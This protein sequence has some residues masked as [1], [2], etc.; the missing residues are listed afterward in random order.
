MMHTKAVATIMGIIAAFIVVSLLMA[1]ML[2]DAKLKSTLSES[3]LK[4]LNGEKVTA[5]DIW[6]M[7]VHCVVESGPEATIATAVSSG[8]DM[9]IG[10]DDDISVECIDTHV[11]YKVGKWAGVH[12]KE[13]LKGIYVGVVGDDESKTLESAE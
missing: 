6:G 7:P 13:L 4:A 8:P 1:S 10:N 5:T 9:Q 12:S 3:A 11:T 2:R